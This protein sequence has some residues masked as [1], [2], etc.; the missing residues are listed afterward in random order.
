MLFKIEPMLRPVGKQGLAVGFLLAVF[1]AFGG[2]PLRGQGA[3]A[4]D[5]VTNPMAGN[6]EAIAAG[7]TLYAQTCAN[8]HGDDARGNRGPSLVSGSFSHGGTDADLFHTVRNGVAGT[9]MPAFAA[10]PADTIWKIIAYLRSLSGVGESVNEVVPGDT[11]AGEKIFWG[12]GGCGACHEVNERGGDVGADLSAAGTSSAATLRGEILNPNAPPGRGRRRRFFGPE[13]LLVTTRDGRPIRGMRRAEDSYTLI[14]TGVDGKLYRFDK[15]DLQAEKA[16]QE[17]LMPT[18][19]GKLLSPA[20]LENLIAYLKCLKARDLTKTIQ[21]SLPDGVGFARLKDSEAEPQNWLTYWGGYKSHH[22]S[23]LNE[24]T[25]ANVHLLQAKWSQQMPGSSVLESTP[26]VVDG[27]MYTSGEPGQVFAIDARS[28]LE[29]WRYERKQRVVNPYQTNPYNRGVAILGDRLFLGTLDAAVVALDARTGRELWET[30]VADT[31]KGYTLTLAPLAMEGKVIVGVAGGEFGI[32][33]FIDA[34]D[35]ATGKRLWRFY[36]IPG[37]GE[38]GNSTWSGDSWKRGGAPTWLTG[39]Y[40][41]ELNLLYWAVG[42]PG[43]DYNGEGREGDD[44][45]SCSVVALDPD[46]GKLKWY[47]QFTPGDTRDWDATEDL[48]LADRVENGRKQKVLLQANR[49]GMYYVLDRTNGKLLLAKPYVRVTWNRGYGTDGRPI[50]A[51]NQQSTP[52]GVVVYPTIGGGSNWQSP[53]YDAAHSMLYVEALDMGNGVRSTPAP[54]DA[55]REWLGGGPYQVASDNRNGVFAIDAETGAVKWKF[56]VE[57]VSPGVGVLATA[58]G[59]VFVSTVEGN[60]IALDAKTG[61][62]LWHFQT[63]GRMNCSPMSYAVD[64][65]QYIAVSAGN[66]LYSFALPEEGAGR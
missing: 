44:L 30:Q 55:G 31:M 5:T 23:A 7:K 51:P 46:T 54:Y 8:C 64:G 29:I 10:L 57:K 26:L 48:V 14:M 9:Q 43:P 28:G 18:D 63:G 16:T 56:P 39:S 49:N 37:A 6:Q 25:P 42:N 27:T 38:P 21:A 2:A 52:Q 40:D 32:R 47:Y 60:L 45:Y 65:R 36:T 62:S 24:I 59:L 50:E 3:V 1:A 22:F 13:S 53:S 17:S 20:E 58:S 15:R 41:P 12:K 4:P 11:A 19:Y 34:Y 61:K 33:G 35:A 66:V